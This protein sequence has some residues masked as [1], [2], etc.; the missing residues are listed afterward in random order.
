MHHQLRLFSLSAA[1]LTGCVHAPSSLSAE[2]RAVLSRPDEQHGALVYVGDVVPDGDTA[3]AFRYERRVAT[4]GTDVVAT[5]VTRAAATD[6][7]LVVQQARTT[8]AGQ[9][10][11]FDEVHAQ[12]A[13][14]ATV[15]VEG[16]G[17][18]RVLRYTVTRDG[19]TAAT[20][21]PVTGPVVVGP[22]LFAFALAKRPVL[23]A[24]GTVPLQ[25][26]VVAAGRSYDFELRGT[27]TARG[28]RAVMTARDLLIGLFV[29]PVTVD[30]IDTDRGVQVERYHGRI[31]PLCHGGP[32]DGE[33]R[34]R[35]VEPVLK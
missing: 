15:V 27:K 8:A 6:E 20:S 10:E 35:F 17:A 3:A 11:R 30:V 16:S 32:C 21:E 24:G 2:A 13:T 28:F 29:A 5:H 1:L 33:V 9:L 14:A 7:A 23:E 34:Y 19:V 22:T 25:F 4:N 31:P 26:V 12:T 18:G